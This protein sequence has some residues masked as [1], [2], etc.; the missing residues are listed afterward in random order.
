MSTAEGEKF[1]SDHG[2]IFLETSAKTAAN[3]EEAFVRTAA[4]I[5]ENIGKGIYDV[6]N[7]AHGIKL[8]VPVSGVA[9]FILLC[10]SKQYRH[11][12][13]GLCV[14][15][16]CVCVCV[17]AGAVGWPRGCS[18]RGGRKSRGWCC[19][20]GC[21]GSCFWLWGLLLMPGRLFHDIDIF[22]AHAVSIVGGGCNRSA[23]Y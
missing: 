18:G 22:F 17:C 1:A 2:L 7:E 14:V 9:S 19:G 12:R 8:G 16:V 15:C 21:A 10:F 4:R 11:N 20:C 6:R 5:Y 13:Y 23:A 3:V